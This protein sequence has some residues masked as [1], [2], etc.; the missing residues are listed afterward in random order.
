MK[1]DSQIEFNL[2]KMQVVTTDFVARSHSDKKQ[3]ETLTSVSFG[4]I[5]FTTKKSNLSELRFF[6]KTQVYTK[7]NEKGSTVTKRAVCT[8]ISCAL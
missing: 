8:H 3:E 5:T 7:N 2:F 4:M 1:N 6:M